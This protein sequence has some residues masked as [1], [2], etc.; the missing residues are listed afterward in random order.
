[1]TS[2]VKA[3][4]DLLNLC[5]HELFVFNLMQTDP[6]WSNFLYNS[7]TRKVGHPV[8]TESQPPAAQHG[9]QIVLVDFGATR[10]YTKNFIANYKALML[11][12]IDEKRQDCLDI[13]RDLGYLTGQE[14][15]VTAV[16]SSFRYVPAKPYVC[17]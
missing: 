1:M 9:S 14:N 16:G 5:L 17:T 4:S 15:E 7:S 13:S 3:G 10:A 11:A 12:A 2:L 8:Q 6:N